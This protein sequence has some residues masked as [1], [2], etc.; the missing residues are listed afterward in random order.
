[1]TST[2][3]IPGEYNK[4]DSRADISKHVATVNDLSTVT[5][6]RL[7]KNSVGVEAAAE[8]GDA[9]AKMTSLKVRS[10]LVCVFVRKF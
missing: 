8:L 10:N 4:L 6:I 1:M 2:F 5:E 9:I 3:T 7:S